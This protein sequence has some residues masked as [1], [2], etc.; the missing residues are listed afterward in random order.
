MDA[1]NH[2][3]DETDWLRQAIAKGLSG[4]L[5]LHLEGGPS[6]ETVAKTAGVWFYVMCSW[7]I[8][9]HEELDRPRLRAAFTA[10][11]SQSRR[12]PSP[13]ELRALLP[14]RVYPDDQLPAPEYP[15][16]KA[17]A[18]RAK[19]KFLLGATFELRDLK[20]DFAKLEAKHQQAPSENSL[21]ALTDLQI[22]I[23]TLQT[24][25]QEAQQP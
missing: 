15:E 21:E 5:V 11:A 1:L 18:N 2:A 6:A 23:D 16:A 25:I 13:S 8:K 12:W 4:L 22:K 14:S 3:D 19:I 7:P 9:W 10:L 24:Q 20:D 17:A